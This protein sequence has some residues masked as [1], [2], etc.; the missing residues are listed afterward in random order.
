MQKS[1]RAMEQRSIVYETSGKIYHQSFAIIGFF[2]LALVVLAIIS[3]YGGQSILGALCLGIGAIFIIRGIGLAR[4]G[5]KYRALAAEERSE[6][7]NK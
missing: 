5:K 6:T 1:E 7:A 2:G 4:A 3:F